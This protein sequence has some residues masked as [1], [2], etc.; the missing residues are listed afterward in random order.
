MTL[1][2][3]LLLTILCALLLAQQT[4]PA[5]APV[6]LTNSKIEM[7]ILPLGSTI[8]GVV[9]RDDPGKMNPLWHPE[10]RIS[11]VGHFLCL[12]GFGGTSPE[13]RKAGL[14][15]H[16]EA[17][18]QHWTYTLNSQGPLSVLTMKT[19]LPIVQEDVTRTYKLAR[20]E[21]VVAVTTEVESLLGFD[22]PMVWAEHATIG[23]PFLESGVTEAD[24]SAKRCLTRPYTASQRGLAHRLP[25][26]KEFTWPDAPALSGGTVDLRTASANSGDHSACLIDASRK[27]A[28]LTELNPRLQLLVG[29]VVHPDEY[30][31]VQ[32]WENYPPDGMMSRGLEFS[33]QP[34]DLPRRQPITE[35]TLFGTQ[36]FRWLPAKSKVSSHFALFYTKTPPTMRHVDDVRVEDGVI[37]IEDHSSH[38]SV[39]LAASV[40][41]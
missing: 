19:R 2:V 21:Q 28:Y 35:K 37:V 14:P 15:G 39:R 10:G 41:Q 23:S 33:T 38:A 11:N 8:A 22:R 27:W 30:P 24:I 36:L 5:E 7:T 18:L 40:I 9:L 20:G 32:N 34:F 25:S 31:W 3:F 13:E 16:G 1:R 17:H 4:P 26:D 12:D 6:H 29:W